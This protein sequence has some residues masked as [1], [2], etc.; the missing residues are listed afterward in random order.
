MPGVTAEARSG[1]RATVAAGAAL[2]MCVAS[3]IEPLPTLPASVHASGGAGGRG[4]AA[5]GRQPMPVVVASTQRWPSGESA[6]GRDRRG[7]PHASST[8][9]AACRAGDPARPAR[10]APG[11]Y[12]ANES[13]PG[14]P[15]HA[16]PA[17]TS[18]R[19][20][21]RFAIRLLLSA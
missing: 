4:V 19:A 10:P 17:T 21:P 18:G 14:S 1:V 15:P 16:L 2:V 20:P 3:A 11:D 9:M 8:S 13:R 12:L 6:V 5:L 7:D